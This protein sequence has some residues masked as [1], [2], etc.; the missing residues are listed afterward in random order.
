M[1][2]ELVILV[3]EMDEPIGSMEKMEAHQ[4][5]LLHRAISVFIFNSN[6]EMLLQQRALTKYHSAGLWSN[7]CC[8]HPRSNETTLEAA[9]RRLR[10]EMGMHAKLEHRDEFIYKVELEKGLSE[11]EYDHVFVGVT[12]E[13][14]ILNPEEV[15]SYKWISLPELQKDIRER[16]EDYTFWFKLLCERLDKLS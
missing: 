16:P 7:T 4:K 13:E 8:S 5:G 3:N 9:Q 15:M 11:H 1:K 10:E 2:P 14:P 12:D 6:Q